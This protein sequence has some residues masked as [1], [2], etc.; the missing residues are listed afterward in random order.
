MSEALIRAQI[1]A[2][3]ETVPG[4]GVVHDYERYAR[5][6][7]DYFVLMTQ[8]GTINGWSIHR[9]ETKSRQITMGLNGQI[10]RVHTYRL[11]GLRE[12]DDAAGSE[13]IFQAVIDGIFGAFKANHTLNGTAESHD[14]IQIDEVTVCIE[15]E[16]AGT[17]YHVADCTL[18][19][20]ERVDIMT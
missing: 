8:D 19:V 1:K 13:K 17:L 2:I 20:T 3:M 14:L 6:L 18:V 15:D 5:S 10:E 4:I 11:A 16:Y 9:E 7:A 12:M